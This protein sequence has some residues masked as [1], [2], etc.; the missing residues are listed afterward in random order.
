MK[1]D[2]KTYQIQCIVC[3]TIKLVT[4]YVLD[5]RRHL[6]PAFCSVCEATTLHKKIS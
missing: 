2:F 5:T 4:Y 6:D 3:R 1:N